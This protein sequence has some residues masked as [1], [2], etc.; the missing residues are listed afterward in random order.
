MFRHI[1]APW[2][3]WFA[4]FI[5]QGVAMF[6]RRHEEYGLPHREAP[7]SSDGAVDASLVVPHPDNRLK[8][9]CRRARRLRVEVHHRATLVSIRDA[10]G[11][12]LARFP[13]REDPSHPIVLLE[14]DRSQ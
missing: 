1:S 12:G 7:A 14:G 9:L 4:H 2:W 6:G 11:G 8:H 5:L 10:Y 3:F 13:E